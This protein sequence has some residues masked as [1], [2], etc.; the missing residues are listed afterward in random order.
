MPYKNIIFVKIKLELIN[1][2][3]Y[4]DRLNDNQKLL[5]LSLIM[6]AGAMDNKIPNDAGYIK[7]QL[8]LK[9]PVETIE[10]DLLVLTDVFPKLLLSNGLLSFTN[11]REIHNFVL[12]NPKSGFGSSQIKSRVDKEKSRVDIDKIRKE[13]ISFNPKVCKMVKETTKKLSL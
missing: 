11:F 12:G 6:L 1:D 2:Y 13:P 5:Y 10:Q 3:R 7:R 9:Y 4:T 8:N